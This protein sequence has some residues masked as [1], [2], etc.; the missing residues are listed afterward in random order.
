MEPWNG[1]AGGR[2][3]QRGKGVGFSLRL[4]ERGPAVRELEVK[5]GGKSCSW[6]L[7]THFRF[8]TRKSENTVFLL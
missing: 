5:V 7:A 6:G 2:P 3:Q 1:A 8:Q 4:P